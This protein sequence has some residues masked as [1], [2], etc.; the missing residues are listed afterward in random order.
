MAK[1]PVLIF[2]VDLHSL[3]P[4]IAATIIIM[5]QV[6]VISGIESQIFTGF[7]NE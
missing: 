7:T 3:V 1:L 4:E 2:L 5:I 6:G